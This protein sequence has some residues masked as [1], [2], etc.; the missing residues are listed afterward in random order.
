MT[1]PNKTVTYKL[2]W[3][4]FQNS[5]FKET[6]WSPDNTEKQFKNL[7]GKF[8][9][10]IE[11]ILKNQTYIRT[12]KY[13]CQNKKF[14]RGSE[15]QNESSRGKKGEKKYE[16]KWRSTQDIENHFKR[17]NLTI[18]GVQEGIEKEKG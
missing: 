11:I 6:Q 7:S 10:D 18:I 14:I 17:P 5:G 12:D 3:Q 8:S 9:K 4:K 15:Q 2:S 16:K 13:I 1:D